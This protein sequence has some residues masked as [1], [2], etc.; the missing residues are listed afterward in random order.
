MG[1]A[2]AS[3]RVCV[4]VTAAAVLSNEF[5]ARRVL[6]SV[7]VLVRRVKLTPKLIIQLI[8]RK[9]MHRTSIINV[10]FRVEH[11]INSICFIYY[12][13]ITAHYNYRARGDHRS[14]YL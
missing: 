4:E 5:R 13:A 11:A 8:N 1:G 7:P 9:Q 12:E 10:L 6:S 14:I 3:W 2:R